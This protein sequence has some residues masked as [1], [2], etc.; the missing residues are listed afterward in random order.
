MEQ[1]IRLGIFCVIALVVIKF[2]RGA[3]NPAPAEIK[4]EGNKEYAPPESNYSYINK[5]KFYRAGQPQLIEMFG[6]HCPPCKQMVPHMARMQQEYKQCWIMSV[7]SDQ[8]AD[9]Q[10]FIEENPAAKQYNISRDA[11]GR[12]GAMMQR[13]VL[14]VFLTVSYLTSKVK[15]FITDIL[16]KL[17]H[18]LK[19]WIKDRMVG[20]MLEKVGN[21]ELLKLLNNI[22]QMKQRSNIFNN[23]YQ[24]LSPHFTAMIITLQLVI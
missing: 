22:L 10:K 16:I 8:E 2:V 1:Y 21:Y 7:T 15:W 18:I 20:K 23:I 17:S 6:T 11:G 13:L 24:Y 19:H 3:R 5:V 12:V 14:K 9:V 4:Q